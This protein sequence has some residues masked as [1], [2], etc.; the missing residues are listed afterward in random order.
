MIYVCPLDRMPEAAADLRPS[1]LISLLDPDHAVSTP[2]GLAPKNHLKIGIHDISEPFDGYV[3]PARE[4]IEAVLDFAAAWDRSAPMLVHCFA[5]ISRSMAAALIL[6]CQ[7]NEGRERDAAALVRARAAHAMP[8]R[9][10]IALAD[11]VMKLGGR[12]VRAVEEMPPGD[13]AL[14][15]SLVAL[16]VAL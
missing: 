6:L 7:R 11:E 3:A 9:R 12:L 8:N 10:M 15:G 13:F 1:H 14:H 2:P 4:H 5:G 16:P